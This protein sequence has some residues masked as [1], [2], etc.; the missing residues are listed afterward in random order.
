MDSRVALIKPSLF[1]VPTLFLEAS[2]TNFT[3]LSSACEC[4]GNLIKVPAVHWHIVLYH[5]QKFMRTDLPE[6]WRQCGIKSFQV[7]E[8]YVICSPKVNSSNNEST[9]TIIIWA[10]FPFLDNSPS[11][12]GSNMASLIS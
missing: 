10:N 5:L 11:C 7:S 1:C 6:N 12:K 3:I 9:N 8:I 2:V 4:E